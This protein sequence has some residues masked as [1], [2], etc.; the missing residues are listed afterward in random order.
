MF[1]IYNFQ[2]I[3]IFLNI[4]HFRNNKMHLSYFFTF[5]GFLKRISCPLCGIWFSSEVTLSR[6]KMW[7]HKSNISHYRF[8]C[9]LCP[10]ST[11]ESTHFKTHKFVHDPQRP[12]SCSEC[13]NRFK[14]INAL[15]S[16]NIIHTGEDPLYFTQ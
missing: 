5:S 8:N 2:L 1:L 9:H 3:F 6:H 4:F 12:Y 14:S 7:H 11:N 13:G 10:Y 15:K 16:H